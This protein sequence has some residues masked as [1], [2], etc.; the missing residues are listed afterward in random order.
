MIVTDSTGLIHLLSQSPPQVLDPNTGRHVSEVRARV[1]YYL[2][3]LHRKKEK[4]LI[5]TPVL[6]ELLILGDHDSPSIYNKLRRSAV[7]RIASFDDRAAIELSIM[8]GKAIKAGDKKAGSTASVAKVKYDRQIIATGIVNRAH[9]VFSDD[10]NVIRFAKAHGI[11]VVS[12]W[13]LPLP[14]Q[15]AQPLLWDQLRDENEKETA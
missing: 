14:P 11:M 7:F 8:T 6:A 10:E 2:S 5:P 12:I 13:D 9:T 1:E 15:D 3:E 4:V